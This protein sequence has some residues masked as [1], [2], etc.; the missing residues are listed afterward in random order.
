M[1]TCITEISNSATFYSVHTF[2]PFWG[3]IIHYLILE[4]KYRQ[5]VFQMISDIYCIDYKLYFLV[6]S[7]IKF[8]KI[9]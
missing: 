6:S 2:L 8:T 5:C 4:Y 9:K 1:K 7:E 3:Y